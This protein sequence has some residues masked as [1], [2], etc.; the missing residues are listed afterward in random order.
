MTTALHDLE[1]HL[2]ARRALP[3]PSE[4]RAIR[5]AARV[6]LQRLARAVG[7]TRQT[8]ALW[9]T[10]RAAPRDAHLD[11]YLNALRLMEEAGGP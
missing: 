3:P 8:I 2:A 6:S 7:V 9:E 4:R 5:V 1:S 10:G 11:A